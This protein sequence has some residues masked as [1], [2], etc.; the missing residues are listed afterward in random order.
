MVMDPPNTDRP[1][2]TV[3]MPVS[4]IEASWV[5]NKPARVAPEKAT[6]AP[7]D[8][9]SPGRF[10][11]KPPSAASGPI[12][13]SRTTSWATTTTIVVKPSV[14]LGFARM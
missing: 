5:M 13:S 12:C 9:A 7:V 4:R 2:T 8:G 6:S 3:S 14:A 10:G 11:S 1:M